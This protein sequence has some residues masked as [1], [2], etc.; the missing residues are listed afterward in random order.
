M[1]GFQ[2]LRCLWKH[3]DQCF[4]L[5]FGNFQKSKINSKITPKVFENNICGFQTQVCSIQ[6]QYMTMTILYLI[7]HKSLTN[8]HNTFQLD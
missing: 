8:I 1:D 6:R 7:L 4:H 5:L 3:P 2:I